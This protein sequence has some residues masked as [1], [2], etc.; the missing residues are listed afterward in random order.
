MVDVS[1]ERRLLQAVGIIVVV[2]VVLVVVLLLA[3]NFA[4]G[5]VRSLAPSISPVGVGGVGGGTIGITN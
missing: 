5:I 1:L 3:G 2:V 4:P